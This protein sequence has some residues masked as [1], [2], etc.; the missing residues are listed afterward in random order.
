LVGRTDGKRTLGTTR[1]RC[2]GKIKIYFQKF[3]WGNVEGLIG[4]RIGTRDELL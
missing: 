4:V 1:R 2:E 3:G